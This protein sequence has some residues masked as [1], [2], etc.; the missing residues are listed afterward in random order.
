[1]P[2]PPCGPRPPHLVQ[3][4]H[5]GGWGRRGAAGHTTRRLPPAPLKQPQQ[6]QWGRGRRRVCSACLG[7][8]GGPHQRQLRGVLLQQRQASTCGPLLA[9]AQAA[10]L[11]L[12]MVSH[13][14]PLL[15]HPCTSTRVEFAADW[16]PAVGK[17]R[18]ADAV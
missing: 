4:T 6:Q 10:L 9:A 7:S 2:L 3:W 14:G 16:A 18:L 8:R 12:P 13:L 17:E 1:V 5:G 15:L 11:L